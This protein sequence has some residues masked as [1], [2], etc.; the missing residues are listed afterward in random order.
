MA[1]GS[2]DLAFQ[3]LCQISLVMDL[4]KAIENGQ[5]VDFLVVLGFDIPTRKIAVD[6]IADTEVIS[7]LQQPRVIELAIVDK[8][9]IRTLLIIYEVTLTA[10]LNLGMPPG[11]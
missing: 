9:S 4:C 6:T 10:R 8:C 3:K 7:I 11:Y 2:N 1:L 5:P